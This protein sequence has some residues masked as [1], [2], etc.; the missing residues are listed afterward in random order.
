MIYVNCHE[1]KDMVEYLSNSAE[2]E[3]KNFTPADYV[4]GN[5]GIERKTINDFLSSLIQNRLFEQLSRLKGCYQNCIL[6]IEAFD[7]S[8]FSNTNAIY[9]AILKIIMEMNIKLI[10]SQTKEQSADILLILHKNVTKQ[11][12]HKLLRYQLKYKKRG[13]G[14]AKKQ[15]H[16]LSSIPNV[17]TKRAKLLLEKFKSISDI[18]DAEDKTLLSIEGIGKKTITNIRRMLGK[19]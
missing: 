6:L 3:V 11:Y 16:M 10:F 15:L 17:G 7:L 4:I 1:P 9:G 5:I 12:N 13:I 18:F 2:V 19:S 14:L 8:H